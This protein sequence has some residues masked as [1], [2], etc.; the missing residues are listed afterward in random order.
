M[1]FVMTHESEQDFGDITLL[2]SVAPLSGMQLEN[3]G[4]M[5]LKFCFDL[6]VVTNPCFVSHSWV[7]L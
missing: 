6:C 4:L 5:L 3:S 2:F 1:V 7:G